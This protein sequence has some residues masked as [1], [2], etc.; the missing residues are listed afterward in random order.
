MSPPRSDAGDDGVLYV[1]RAAQLRRCWHPVAFGHQVA[2]SPIARRV[3]GTPI[4]AW[5]DPAGR[6]AAALDRCPHRWARLSAGTVIDGL[7]S[8]PYHGWRFDSTGAAVE[9][10]QREPDRAIPPGAHL[11]TVAVQERFGM[12]WVSLDPSPDF[13]LPTIPE[14]DDDRFRAIEVGVV[15]YET[16]AAAVIDNNTDA[17]H[18][19]FVHA[20]SFGADQDPRIATSRVDRTEFGVEIASDDMSVARTPTTRQPGT[21]RAVTQM[22]LPFTQVGRMSYSDGSTHILV[23]GCCPVDDDRTDVHL[24]VLRNDVD[25]P[26][27][28]E[29]VIAFELGVEREDKSI[30]DTVPAA[31]PLDPTLQTHTQHDRPGIVYRLALADLLAARRDRSE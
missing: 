16:S 19:A 31:F 27:D 13:G 7:L 9:I 23:K 20:P 29:A 14:F 10:P 3:L 4:V 24:A 26:A 21:R 22:W 6:V 28:A 2:S 12:V 18:V 30:L 1:T 25:D 5:R 8:C 11:D 17:T 15:T